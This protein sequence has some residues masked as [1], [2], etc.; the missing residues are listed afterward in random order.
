MK[1]VGCV[2]SMSCMGTDPWVSCVTRTRK[3]HA[4]RCAM[5]AA[6]PRRCSC[7]SSH[8]SAPLL[9]LLAREDFTLPV[10]RSIMLPVRAAGMHS[11]P[12]TV[13]T[14][15]RV[16]QSDQITIVCEVTAL[17]LKC[18]PCVYTVERAKAHRCRSSKGNQLRPLMSILPSRISSLRCLQCHGDAALSE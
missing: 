17:G 12:F 10:L 6:V 8:F 4:L 2:R 3:P 1:A 7:T 5:H 11:M 13:W 9:V 14:Q 18:T 15:C 16:E